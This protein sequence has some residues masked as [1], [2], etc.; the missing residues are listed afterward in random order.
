MFK[1]K[2]FSQKIIF[3]FSAAFL[4]KGMCVAVDDDI[5]IIL[6]ELSLNALTGLIKLIVL[7]FF[8]IKSDLFLSIS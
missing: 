5:N 1:S 7:N 2:G 4:I 8:E 6:I 3:L